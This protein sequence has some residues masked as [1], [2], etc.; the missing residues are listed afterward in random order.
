[1]SALSVQ[2]LHGLVSPAPRLRFANPQAPGDD[3][4]R[5]L[6]R[7]NCSMTPRQLFGF[8]ASLCLLLLGIAVFFWWR[9]APLV[10]PFAGA[11]LL[12]VGAAFLV[13][14]RH[15]ADRESV[16]LVPGRLS[17]ECRLGRRI[18][19]AEF[20]PSWA[21]VEPR[22]DDGSLIEISGEGRQIAVGRFVRPELRPALADELRAALRRGGAP[23]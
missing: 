22:H 20:A 9:G 17:V 18:E 12:A 14:A 13:Y 19:R 21:R 10:L 23:R 6:L 4:V 15:A 8:Y 7:R 11:E 5:W 2:A 16:V 1:M 3:S